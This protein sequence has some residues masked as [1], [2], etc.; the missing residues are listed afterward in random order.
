MNNPNPH[1]GFSWMFRFVLL[2]QLIEKRSLLLAVIQAAIVVLLC[3]FLPKHFARIL[4]YGKLIKYAHVVLDWVWRRE[5]AERGFGVPPWFLAVQVP[6]LTMQRTKS[7][8]L[9]IRRRNQ[10]IRGT[11]TVHS[12]IIIAPL[13]NKHYAWFRRL[14]EQIRAHKCHFS[15]IGIKWSSTWIR[16]AFLKNLHISFMRRLKDLQCFQM[17]LW[18]GLKDWSFYGL[19]L[20]MNRFTQTRAI[21]NILTYRLVPLMII[22]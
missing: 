6:S 20:E 4:F 11:I 17:Y 19:R 5:Q 3:V 18:V 22:Q 16:D 15:N 13:A 1:R 12:V 14:P 7:R 2:D 21:L 10:R 9:H 8:D